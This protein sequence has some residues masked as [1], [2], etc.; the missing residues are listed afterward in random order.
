MLRSMNSIKLLNDQYF[1]ELYL[2]EQKKK[3]KVKG[4]SKEDLQILS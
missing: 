2:E 4:W 1:G 3:K